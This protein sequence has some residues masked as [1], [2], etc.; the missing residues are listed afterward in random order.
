MRILDENNVEII[1]PDLTLGYLKEDKIFIQ[2][3]E[4]IDH[5]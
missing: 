4:V 2:H 5:G 3:H 1:S